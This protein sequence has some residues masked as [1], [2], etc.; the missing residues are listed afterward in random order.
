MV[1]LGYIP[2]VDHGVKVYKHFKC[3]VYSDYLL[4]TFYK[5]TLYSPQKYMKYFISLPLIK[6]WII[7]IYKTY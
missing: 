4:G 2:N 5:L 3:S 7:Y 6:H 1:S